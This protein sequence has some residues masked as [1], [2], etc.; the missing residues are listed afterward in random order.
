MNRRLLLVASAAA[1]AGCARS[2]AELSPAVGTVPAPGPGEGAVATAAGVL[3]SAHAQAWHFDPPD[4]ETKVTPILIAVT[5]NRDRS[6]VIRYQDIVLADNGGTRYDVIPPYN[7]NAKLHVPITI[8]DPYL[9]TG[10]LYNYRYAP[11]YVRYNGGYFYDP[12]V[13]YRPY[14]TV[15]TDVALPTP[16]MV[17]RSLREGVVAAGGTAGGFVYFQAFHRGERVLTL[18]VNIVD[19]ASSTVIG[20][21]RIPF[22]AS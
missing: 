7:I 21:V 14:T 8:Q 13:E 17:T 9:Y 22:V 2:Y 12:Y 19:E 4:L 10:Y 1:I 11:M 5:N 20:T 15:Y 3:V 18:I 6:I 16:E